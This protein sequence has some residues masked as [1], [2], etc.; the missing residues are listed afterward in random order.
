MRKPDP[1][2]M[3]RWSYQLLKRKWNSDNHHHRLS[4]YGISN[5]NASTGREHHISLRIYDDVQRGS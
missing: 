4:L 1:T 3:G 5:I 2:G